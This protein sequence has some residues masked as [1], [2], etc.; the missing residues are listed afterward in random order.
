MVEHQDER[1]AVAGAGDDVREVRVGEGAGL[2]HDSLVGTVGGQG[3]ELRAR[4]GLHASA[5]GAQVGDDGRERG[6]P[7]R[8][9]GHEGALHGEAA[10]QGL[11][12]G[13]TALDDVAGEAPRERVP[14]AGT[15]LRRLPGGRPRPPFRHA[16]RGPGTRGARAAGS[17]ALPPRGAVPGPLRPLVAPGALRSRR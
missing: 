12:R 9:L 13:A 17:G 7:A 1:R 10:A 11:S 15:A 14:A 8:A 2:E 6:V 4:D 5:G 16:V 3:V